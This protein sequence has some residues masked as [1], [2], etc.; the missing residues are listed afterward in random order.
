MS[1]PIFDG[2]RHCAMNVSSYKVQ[3]GCFKTRRHTENTRTKNVYYSNA[4]IVD[5]SLKKVARKY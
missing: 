4:E 3:D 2:I 1:K 5:I